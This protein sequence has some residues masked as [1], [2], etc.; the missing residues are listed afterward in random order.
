MICCRTLA[1]LAFLSAALCGADAFVIQSNVHAASVVS[2]STTS[3]SSAFPSKLA[4]LQ[5]TSSSTVTLSAATVDPTSFLSDAL[6][7]V[8]GSNL[9]LAVPI[10]AALGVAGLVVFLIVA[11]ANPAE[12]DD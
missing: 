5:E 8:I 9:I 6:G 1:L 4:L 10:V 7:G 3:S 2:L 12:S 11:Y